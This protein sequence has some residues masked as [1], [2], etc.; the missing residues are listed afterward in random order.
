MSFTFPKAQK[1]KRKRDIDELFTSGKSL[2]ISIL[3]VNYRIINEGSDY[4]LLAGFSV[5]KKTFKKAVMRNL[6]KRRMREAYRLNKHFVADKLKGLKLTIHLMFIYKADRVISFDEIEKIM[7]ELL[8]S[9]GLVIESNK[10]DMP[11]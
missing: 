6:I 3:R 10:S 7:I 1:L 4:P 8:N 2:S 9:F 11:L 5:S